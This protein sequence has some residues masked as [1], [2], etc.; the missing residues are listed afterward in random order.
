[1]ERFLVLCEVASEEEI[2]IEINEAKRF[3]CT[4][5]KFSTNQKWILNRHYLIHTGQKPYTCDVCNKRFRQS[6]HKADHMKRF[7]AS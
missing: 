2:T 1:M 5:C 3:R 7:H 4:K 6:A